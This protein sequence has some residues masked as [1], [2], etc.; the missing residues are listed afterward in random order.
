MII[1][2]C[3][4]LEMRNWINEIVNKAYCALNSVIVHCWCNL[5]LQADIKKYPHSVISRLK[6]K[7]TTGRVWPL[8]VNGIC[9]KLDILHANQFNYFYRVSFSFFFLFLLRVILFRNICCYVLLLIFFSLP[10]I[11]YFLN[12]RCGEFWILSTKNKFRST[13]SNSTL[14]VCPF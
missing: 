12:I 14:S 5:P 9:R 6:S 13:I 7:W 1:Y 10:L 3:L 2:I 4:Y 8:Q 11:L